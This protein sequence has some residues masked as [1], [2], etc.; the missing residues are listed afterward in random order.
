M[1]APRP[2][3]PEMQEARDRVK[4]A[5]QENGIAFL[6]GATPENVREKIDEGVRVISGHREETARIGRAHTKRAMPV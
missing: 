6:E 5:C 1:S 2:Y 3:P 4:A